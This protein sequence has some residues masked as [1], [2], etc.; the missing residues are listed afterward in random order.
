MSG[1]VRL[2]VDRGDVLGRI[3]DGLHDVV[4]QLEST[5]HALVGG[6]AVLVRVQGHRVTHDI[7][8][9]VRGPEADIRRRLAVVGV[10]AGKRDATVVLEN[11]VPV[12]VLYAGAR[13]PRKGIGVFR[14]AKAHAVGWAIEI[15]EPITVDTEPSASRGP[16][17]LPV[18]KA[19]ALVA[20]KTVAIADPRRGDKR[21]T[22]LLDVW[23][24]LADD[25]I[26]TGQH[27]E[28]FGNAPPVL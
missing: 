26:M 8:S 12:D 7:D 15:A 10:P 23:R 13:P 18:A 3:V 28:E 16:I 4:A 21:A 14:E 22:D 1:D 2:L 19:S 9:A 5:P 11:G 20:M 24:L 6:V 25:P 27:I 17:T